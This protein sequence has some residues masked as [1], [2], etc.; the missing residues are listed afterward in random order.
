MKMNQEE[1]KAKGFDIGVL[2]HHGRVL[3]R[4]IEFVMFLISNLESCESR[5]SGERMTSLAVSDLNLFNKA[6]SEI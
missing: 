2:D 5:M 4:I 1:S 6:R 3:E